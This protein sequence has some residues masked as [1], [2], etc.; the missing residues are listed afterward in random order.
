MQAIKKN[1]LKNIEYGACD[2]EALCNMLGN[3][4]IDNTLY[5]FSNYKELAQ[6][7]TK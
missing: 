4:L 7:I 1:V 5:T 6:N 3:N 2:S